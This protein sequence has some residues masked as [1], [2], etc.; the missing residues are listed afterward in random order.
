[1][2]EER[3]L[4]VSTVVIDLIVENYGRIEGIYGLITARLKPF[5]SAIEV[6][7]YDEAGLELVS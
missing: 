1:M 5:F 3:I 7:N 4:M 2:S 6:D